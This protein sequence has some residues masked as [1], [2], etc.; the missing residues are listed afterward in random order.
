MAQSFIVKKK[1]TKL[2]SMNKLKEQCCQE[3]TEIMEV[4]PAIM[5]ELA[6]IHQLSQA[7]IRH[8]V[9]NEKQGLMGIQKKESLSKGVNHLNALKKAMVRLKAELRHYCSATQACSA[10]SQKA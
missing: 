10:V 1:K 7:N 9:E 4:I 3:L 5:H 2:P 8:Y 6:D